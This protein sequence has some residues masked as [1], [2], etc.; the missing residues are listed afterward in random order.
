M[1]ISLKTPGCCD[2]HDT[3]NDIQRRQQFQLQPTRNQNQAQTPTIALTTKLK[4]SIQQIQ[5]QQ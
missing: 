1:T 5:L 4:E 2:K 3:G